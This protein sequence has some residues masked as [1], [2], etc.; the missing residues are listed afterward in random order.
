MLRAK[1]VVPVIRE[2]HTDISKFSSRNSGCDSKVSRKKAQSAVLSKCKEYA[3]KLAQCPKPAGSCA[4][5]K[6][7][8]S[9][10]TPECE[11]TSV[12]DNY[13]KVQQN[14]TNQ[15]KSI[16][17]D[18]QKES[19]SI[20]RNLKKNIEISKNNEEKR[21]DEF[22]RDIKKRI[23]KLLV[24]DPPFGS[25]KRKSAMLLHHQTRQAFNNLQCDVL[26]RINRIQYIIDNLER[27]M[28][29]SIERAKSLALSCRKCKSSEALEKCIEENG[30][31]AEKILEKTSEG[32]RFGLNKIDKVQREILDYHKAT[33]LDLMK[34]YH[35]KNKALLEH[36][37]NCIFEATN[38]RKR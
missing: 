23:Q 3:D 8:F 25:C 36:L 33:M 13:G 31:Y 2:I 34:A 7:Q 35:K 5:C 32:V 37:D 10:S 16:L 26:P 12:V 27:D 20:L 38:K 28:L 14:L 19:S 4:R 6:W 1:F 15:A 29:I 22:S 30:K 21:L 18:F 11:V 9:D 17:A 24:L